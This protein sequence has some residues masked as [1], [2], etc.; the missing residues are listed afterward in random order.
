MDRKR[1]KSEGKK[2]NEEKDSRT[3]YGPVNIFLINDNDDY[4]MQQVIAYNT[5]II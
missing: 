3:L 2:M 5:F 4:Y 1:L